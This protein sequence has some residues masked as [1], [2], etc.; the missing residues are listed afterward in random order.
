[1]KKENA[2]IVSIKED[3]FILWFSYNVFNILRQVSLF[4]QI[5]NIRKYIFDCNFWSK[6]PNA[7]QELYNSTWKTNTP[8][9]YT[10][11]FS[12]LWLIGNIIL[13]ITGYYLLLFCKNRFLCWIF[14]IYAIFRILEIFIYQVNALLFDPIKSKVNNEE[15]KIKSATRMVIMLLLNILEYI[16]WFSAIYVFAYNTS[17]LC[18]DCSNVVFDSIM[19]LA[20]IAEPKHVDD[21]IIIIIA[22]IESI[23]GIFMNIICLARFISLLPPV[24]TINNN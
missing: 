15:Y 1:M 16:I 21:P 9:C 14:V 18:T 24:K 7:T 13:G 4:Q 11:H 5:R 10:H 12:E 8:F 17:E 23:I 3:G 2:K 20:N 6:N 22:Y 19:T